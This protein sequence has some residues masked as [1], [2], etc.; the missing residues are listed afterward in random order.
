MGNESVG[1]EDWSGENEVLASPAKTTSNS[2]SVNQSSSRERRRTR[3]VIAAK[4]FEENSIDRVVH[5]QPLFD[6]PTKV[7]KQN[8]LDSPSI[9][10]S[11]FKNP[12]REGSSHFSVEE[13]SLDGSRSLTS[14][15]D[16]RSYRDKLRDRFHAVKY[17]TPEEAAKTNKGRPTILGKDIEEDLVQYCLAMEA[18]FFGLTRADLR[19][20]AVQLAERNNTAHP[21]KD[22]IAGK[23]WKRQQEIIRPS[24]RREKNVLST[25]HKLLNW[26]LTQINH[27]RLQQ[28]AVLLCP[29]FLV[30]NSFLKILKLPLLL[31]P[32]LLTSPPFQKF[33]KGALIGD[34]RP[35]ALR[36]LHL[37]LTKPN[38]RKSIKGFVVVVGATVAGNVYQHLH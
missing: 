37:R 31:K 18:S 17:R 11:Q 20:I 2:P 34:E 4:E 25:N 3:K 35:S 7:L 12:A 10:N 14:Q 23:K 8:V 33:I 24:Q 26:S 19:R 6:T 38:M 1:Q 16:N 27:Q 9:E 29:Q 22:E 13:S 30:N 21:F 28:L 36:S 15:S 32:A 5:N